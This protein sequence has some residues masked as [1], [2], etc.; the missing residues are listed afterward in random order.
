MFYST[1]DTRTA[2]A[3]AELVNARISR[4]PTTDSTE[5]GEGRTAQDARADAV[6]SPGLPEATTDVV[7]GRN[8]QKS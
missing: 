5:P 7:S 8:G 1:I 4:R 3:I 6:V 2:R